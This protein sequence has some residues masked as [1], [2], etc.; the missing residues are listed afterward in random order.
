MLLR[1]A[2]PI[3]AGHRGLAVLHALLRANGD[4]RPLALEPTDSGRRPS[5]AVLPFA[6]LSD[7][8]AQ[9]YFADGIAE[10]IIAALSRF[11]WFFVAARNSSFTFKGKTVDVKAVARDLDMRYVL[12]GS[13]R[14]SGR[15]MRIAARLSDA[16]NALQLWADRYDVELG[17][18]F[19]LQD[20]IAEQV[21]GAIEPE[22][23]RTESALAAKRRRSG[24]VNAWDL[25]YQGTWLFHH[26]TRDTHLRARQ[27]FRQAR[28]LDPEL[29][30][31][32]LWLARVNAGIVAYGW[33]S[34]AAEDLQEGENAAL[35]AVRNDERNP[36]AHYSLA[37][38]SVYSGP[39]DRAIQA[40]RKAL[41]LS[42]SF[43]LGHLVLGLALLS[44]PGDQEAAGPLQHGLRLNPYDPQNFV[45]YNALALA[46]LLPEKRAKAA[47]LRS[48]H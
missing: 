16:R 39:L 20:T 8:P 23:L 46:R 27:L 7:D 28:D 4:V 42:P 11:R 10:D 33:T 37:I 25:V 19:A 40:G 6:N 5:L 3:S 9:E 35:E 21:A 14:K 44:A 18:F 2:V 30:E 38:I 41:E 24:N 15:Q 22:L 26:V 31:A 45:W 43:A 36:Y 12:E 34:N 1:D 13:V 32:S 29:P 48:A 17:D 47:R